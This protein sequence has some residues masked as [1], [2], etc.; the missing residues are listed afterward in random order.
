MQPKKSEGLQLK[1]FQKLDNANRPVK[2]VLPLSGNGLSSLPLVYF[3]HVAV[4]GIWSTSTCSRQPYLHLLVAF[5]SRGH[6]LLG[7]SVT[8]QASLSS[9]TTTVGTLS[10]CR[11]YFNSKIRPELMLL[12]PGV[13][14]RGARATLA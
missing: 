2:G 4:A 9:L 8:V 3:V 7:P 6:S 13:M 5:L 10:T 14:P 11:V 1:S 12:S